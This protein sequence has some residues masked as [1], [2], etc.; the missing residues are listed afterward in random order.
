MPIQVVILAAGQG[1]R[2]HSALPK[3][4]HSLAGIPLLQHVLATALAVKSTTQPIVVY[5]HEGERLQHA[6]AHYD[7]KWVEQKIQKGTGHAL[8]Q[9]MPLIHE[10]DQVLV[11]YGDV[12]LITLP[13]LQELITRTKNKDIGI[14][15]ANLI[16][17][18]GYGRI[19]RNEKEEVTA[20]IEEKDANTNEQTIKEVNSGIYLLPAAFL[21][22]YLPGLTA[23][24]AQQEYYLTDVIPFAVQERLAIHTIHAAYPEEIQ[25]VND[26]Q[27][28]MQLERFY[29][30]RY[31]EKLMAEGVTLYDAN[32]FDV[33]GEA[34]V[35]KDVTI[36]I[37]VLLEGRVVIGNHCVIGPNVVLRN[38]ILQEGVKVLAHSII[39]GAEIGRDCQIGPF[40]RIR[41]G[42]VLRDRVHIGNFVEIKNSQVGEK[43]KINH[44]SYIGDSEIGKE[45]NVGAGTITCNYDGIN[46]HKTIIHDYVFI[47]SATQLVAPLVVGEGATIGAG[48]TLT[49]DAPPH[50]LTLSRTAQQSIAG[51]QR[52]RKQEKDRV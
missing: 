25:G 32:R 28:L 18:K 39:D 47:G 37:N 38:T 35:G 30:R 49:K 44:L 8:L 2:M 26:R 4:M 7:L 50:Q 45:V 29:Q 16:D 21:K 51:W 41:P 27:Q 19:K 17:P 34:I 24:N 40:A 5:G 46:K 43:T 52:S 15:T 3:V 14:L 23:H 33:R 22:K 9:A 36:D 13:T 42:T 48:S 20:I 1:K 11:L 31:A 10:D 12:P 6:F